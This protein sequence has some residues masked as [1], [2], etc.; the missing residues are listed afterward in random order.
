MVPI[1]PSFYK[2]YRDDIYNRC[3]KNTVDK[4]YDGLNKC[5]AKVKLTIETNLLSFLDTEIIH[6]NGILETQVHRKKT[7]LPTP[8][9]FNIP[10]RYKQTTIK[11]ELY[12]AKPTSSNFTNEVPL[13][14]NKFK[15]ADYS[16]PFVNSIIHEFTTAQTNEA[17][18]FIIPLW[19]FEFQK[20]I[21]LVKI[22]YCLKK[23]IS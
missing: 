14:R 22:P 5:L 4:L 15:L 12:Q 8:W 23:K 20:K 11:A 9:I 17:N 13:I 7:K 6:N 1:R 2:R 10:K 16:M 19:L 21:V 3:Q 18:E